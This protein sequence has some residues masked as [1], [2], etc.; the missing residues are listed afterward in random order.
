MSTLIK[1]KGNMLLYSGVGD[2]YGLAFEFSSKEFTDKHNDVLN[3]KRREKLSKG[4]EKH[5]SGQYSD[6]TDCSLA[7]VTTLL[8]LDGQF[9]AKYFLTCWKSNLQENPDR[10][11]SKT[12]KHQLLNLSEQEILTGD[13]NSTTNGCLMG[14]QFLGLLPT[15]EKF[16][17]ASVAKCL[18]MHANPDCVKAT[19]FIAY[20]AHNLYYKTKS[21]DEAI[22]MIKMQHEFK[23]VFK[24]V[25]CDATSTVNG[26]L[27]AL[28]GKTKTEVLKRSVDLLGDVD[29]VASIAL[30]LHAL[31]A[32]VTDVLPAIFYENLERPNYYKETE[33]LF[34]MYWRR[35]E[36]KFPITS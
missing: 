20:L 35:L 16:A 14:A 12:T 33:N 19:T 7:V 28:Q 17:K 8:S 15:P 13:R 10:G 26:V 24:K 27:Y 6:D 29:S 4:W 18:P 21:V 3:Y 25:E 30:G 32:E 23:S 34:Y 36:N 31:N 5:Q 9:D 22:S 1:N 2:S 11:Y